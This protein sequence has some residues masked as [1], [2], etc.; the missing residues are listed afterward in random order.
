VL[1]RLLD[2]VLDFIGIFRFGVVLD[3]FENGVILRFGKLRTVMTEPGFYWLAPF[4]IDRAITDT[5]VIAARDLPTQ[6]VTLSDGV[7][8]IAGP[9]VSFKTSDPEKFFLQVDN[10]EA[11]LADSARGTIREVLSGMTW[12]QV[13]GPDQAVA[14][15]LTKAVRKQAWKFGIEVTQVSLA[16]LARA[17]VLR[18]VTG[19]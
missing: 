12:D 13:S 14:E 1:D 4:Y 19:G 17:K 18:V 8:V 15:A 9:V 2:L 7:T 6:S 16:D 10:A 3:N 5:S 11:A